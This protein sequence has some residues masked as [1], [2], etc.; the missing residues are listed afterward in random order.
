MGFVGGMKY[1]VE[2]AGAAWITSQNT[3]SRGLQLDLESEEGGISGMIWVTER[4]AEVAERQFRA[5]GVSDEQLTDPNYME[6]QLPADLL[7]RSVKIA[8]EEEEYKGRTSVKVKGIYPPVQETASGIGGGVAN[9]FRKYKGLPEANAKPQAAPA[10]D[11]GA[12]IMDDD[13]P[14]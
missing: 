12:A 2:V 13:I 5:L 11:G 9:V 10:S 3:G 8:T 4:S 7:G 6:Y 1:L 14:F